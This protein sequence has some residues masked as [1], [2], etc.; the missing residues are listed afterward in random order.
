MTWIKFCGTT[1]L[2]DA[3]KAASLGVNALGFIFAP[4]PRR[5]EPEAAKK[6]ILSLPRT[7]LKVGVFV[8]EEAKEV[9]RVAGYCGLTAL[10][11]HGKESPEYCRGFS[12]PVYKAI[13][14][15]DLESLT[16]ME[17]YPDVSILLDA[18][19]PAQAGGTGSSFP[20]E[21]AIA[22]REKRNFIL[23]GGLNPSKVGE[24][25]RKVRPLG[26]D[27]CSGIE[28]TPGRKDLSK[29]IEFIE[30]VKKADETAG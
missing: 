2:E 4:S 6:I 25:I 30:E 15:K 17:R 19:S 16:D 21:I 5:I 11:F 28:R 12:L 1:N 26:V 8:D 14:V 10:Q 7:L 18:Y 27:V 22:A 20:W 13:P 24:A 29:M 23:S 9:Q 3:L